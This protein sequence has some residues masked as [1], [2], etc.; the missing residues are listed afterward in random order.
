M[1][2]PYRFLCV[3]LP[4]AASSSPSSTVVAA[5]H[6]RSIV[7][8]LVARSRFP[9][10]RLERN[11]PSLMRRPSLLARLSTSPGAKSCASA[12][13]PRAS[14]LPGISV[15]TTGR[16]QVTCS[17]FALAGPLSLGCGDINTVPTQHARLHPA[18]H[19]PR[20]G[21]RHHQHRKD[22]LDAPNHGGQR[23]DRLLRNER[24]PSRF[25]QSGRTSRQVM[26]TGFTGSHFRRGCGRGYCPS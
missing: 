14:R 15:A 24:M 18:V 22:F 16:P 1:D 9:V 21:T 8:S 12:L 5:P 2:R 11:S 10:A 6:I 13:S 25:A 19:V 23:L 3:P 17:G 7:N 4:L 26:A 20:K